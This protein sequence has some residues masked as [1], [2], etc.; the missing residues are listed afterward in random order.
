MISKLVSLFLP[1]L[2]YSTPKSM[3]KNN[4]KNDAFKYKPDHVTPVIMEEESDAVAPAGH[5]VYQPA[6]TAIKK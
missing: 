5:M 2:Y 6:V 4:H 1:L 3:L